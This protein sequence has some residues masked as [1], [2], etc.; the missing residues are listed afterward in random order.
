MTKIPRNKLAS[1]IP[2]LKATYAQ[3][4]KEA[5][6]KKAADAE[7]KLRDMG[8]KS[9]AEL[10]HKGVTETLTYLDF[11]H[12]H[13]RSIRT[14]NILERL[15]REI[16]RRT[17]VVGCFPDGKSALMLVCARLRYVATKEW[18]TKRYLNMK[19]LYEMEKENDLKREQEKDGKNGNVA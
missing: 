8:L 13:W 6:L 17:R 11:T 9:A 5:T 18:G 16:R 15:N 3:E 14:N 12:G 19:H 7:Q 1:A 2:L 4:D 10:Y